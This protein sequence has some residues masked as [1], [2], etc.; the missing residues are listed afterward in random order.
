MLVNVTSELPNNELLLQKHFMA[1]ISSVW[2][3]KCRRDPCCFTN[4]YSSA[5]HMFS[6]VK[7]PGGS[8]ENWPMVNF[9]PSFNLVRKA[10]ADAQ[11]KSTLMVIPPPSRNQEYWRNY[12]EL[13][14][15]FLKD[16]HAYKEDFPSVI[17]VSIL[18]PEPSKQAPEPVEQSLL[19]GL[20]FRQA[21]NRLRSVLTQVFIFCC[22][23]GGGHCHSYLSLNKTVILWISWFFLIFSHLCYTK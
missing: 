7:K 8:S 21:E 10:L 22:Y 1:V 20:S 13:E 2:R 23:N 19:S 14:L 18:E 5:L 4:T 11:A 6:P 15:D 3:S 9:R 12:L 17:N 16:Q